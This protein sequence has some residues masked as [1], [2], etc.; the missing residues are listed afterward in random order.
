MVELEPLVDES[1]LWLVHG[2][3]EDHVRLTGSPRGTKI[4]HNWEHL[5]PRFIKVMPTEYKRV[6]ERRRSTT[7]PR[8]V[9]VAAVAGG[10]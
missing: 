3:I 10:S 4:L 9:A 8:P 5:V 1:H 6:L 2:L 7:R